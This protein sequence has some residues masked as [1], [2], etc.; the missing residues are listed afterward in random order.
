V[1]VSQVVF[2]AAV[3]NTG[4]VKQQDRWFVEGAAALGR[5]VTAMGL[6]DTPQPIG[7]FYACP[8]CLM[9]YGPDALD[10]GIFTAEHVPPKAV[11]GRRLLLTCQSCNSSAGS[12][13]DVHAERRE[14]L[15]D[16][17]TSR[18]PGRA[19][20]AEFAVGDT[21]I[22]GDIHRIAD[23]FFM[24]G[25]PEANNPKDVEEATRTLEGWGVEEAGGRIGIRLSE[26]LLPVRAQLSWVR[27]SYLA[28]FAALGW[29][30]VFLKYLEPLK[31]QLADPAA[32]L[33]PPL[34]MVDLAAPRER[35]QLLVCRN[36]TSCAASR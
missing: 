5:T 11:G 17:F 30:Y 26:T 10:A 8:C 34:A 15:H 36:R 18:A 35:R 1:P 16:L 3:P 22:R 21:I 32:S 27:A 2:G 4:W 14:A 20:R 23:S 31:A 12:T 28:V 7:E 29:R 9:A 19:L 25:V 24:A 33:L 6:S 13:F